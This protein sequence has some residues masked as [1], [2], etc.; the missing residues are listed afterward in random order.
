MNKFIL[1]RM[2]VRFK[3]QKT[4]FMI[5][6]LSYYAILALIPT[7]LIAITIAKFFNLQLNLQHLYFFENITI[8][9]SL[10]ITIFIVIITMISR[11]FLSFYKA[12]FQ[13]IKAI[14]LSIISSVFV[15]AFFTFFL[16][17]NTINNTFFNFTFK[18]LMT[19]FFLLILFLFTSDSNFKYSLLF[20]LTFSIILNLIFNCF[21]LA[22]SFLLDYELYYGLLAPFFL[23][24]IAINLSIHLIYIGYICAEEFTKISKIKFVKR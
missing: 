18:I 13:L 15:I 20:S 14:I 3:N 11:C 2:L 19:L 7:F 23:L 22:A 17:T 16:I 5:S 9:W 4:Q 12:K 24:I 8:N 10:N 1:D 6:S 21:L